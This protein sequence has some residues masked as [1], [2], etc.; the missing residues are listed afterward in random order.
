MTIKEAL[1]FGKNLLK[2]YNIQTAQI[3]ARILLQ[4][5]LKMS[6]ENL[7]INYD[8]E[9][10]EVAYEKFK[11]FLELRKK[12]IPIAYLIE[13]KE[14]YGRVF[15]V[16]Q[17][18]LIPRPE[19]EL[20]IDESLKIFS[21]QKEIK[22]LDLGTGSGCLGLSLLAEMPQAHA[23]LIEKS[24]EAIEVAKINCEKLKLTNRCSIIQSD[25]FSSLDVFSE[26]FDLIICNPPYI[27]LTDARVNQEA[28]FEPATAL[29]AEEEGMK[30]ISRILSDIKKFAKNNCILLMEF[31][32]NDE[33]R[34]KEILHKFKFFSFSF[35]EDLAG[36]KRI[37]KVS[38]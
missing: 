6:Y 1:N 5:A 18:V 22:I 9:I 21:E 32:A 31:G 25:W 11:S 2:Q 28:R 4:K 14:F 17:N 35:I 3:D 38:L 7:L 30:D 23:I 13:E 33:N 16:N 12:H 24:H 15:F 20:F 36:I 8:D 37:V 34:V 26:K 19:S 10:K 27:S 29:F